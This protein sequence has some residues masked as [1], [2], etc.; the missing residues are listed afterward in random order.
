MGAAGEGEGCGSGP[1]WED[2][3]LHR[4]GCLSTCRAPR[5]KGQGHSPCVSLFADQEWQCKRGVGG[6]AVLITGFLE[7]AVSELTLRSYTRPAVAGAGDGQQRR[8]RG[9]AKA[10]ILTPWQSAGAWLRER[11]GRGRLHKVP[12]TSFL[13]DWQ[14]RGCRLGIDGALAVCRRLWYPPGPCTGPGKGEQAGL[15]PAR[16]VVG[17]PTGVDSRRPVPWGMTSQAPFRR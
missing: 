5:P 1:A 17:S 2:T 7:E 16:C 3:G 15:T 13:S 4:G 12:L 9:V 11:R 8:G 14:I 6:E 10:T